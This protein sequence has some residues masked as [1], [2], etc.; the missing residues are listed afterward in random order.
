MTLPPPSGQPVDLAA[1]GEAAI[2]C[3]GLV[4][5]YGQTVAVAGL[6]LDFPKGSFFGL[7]GPNGAGKTTTLSMVTGLLRP[8]A[9]SVRV[10]GKDVWTD[11][12]AAKRMLGVLP[13]GMRLFDRLT[14]L[15]LVTYAGLLRGMDRAVVVGR[16][17]ELLAA[18]GLGGDASTLVVDY[19]AGMTKKV[20]LACA[21][22]HAPRVLVLDEPF[23]GVD[24]VSASTIK[25]ILDSYVA[26][27]RDGRAVQPRHGAGRAPVLARRGYRG[28]PGPRCRLGR[29]SASRD[30]PAG[31]VRRPRRGPHPHRR[32]VVVAHLVRLKLLLL[33]N[34]LKRRPSQLIGLG[35][36]VLYGGF[37]VVVACAGLVALRFAPDPRLGG[38]LVTVLGS[39]LVLAWGVVPLFAFGTDPT[40][41]PRRFATFAISSRQ[42]ALGLAASGLVGLPALAWTRATAAMV[43]NPRGVTAISASEK[44]A[45]LGMF[46]RLP[47]TPVGAVAARSLT[48]WRRDPRYQVS[49]LALLLVPLVLLVA[50]TASGAS[51]TAFLGMPVLTRRFPVSGPGVTVRWRAEGLPGS[52]VAGVGR[53]RGSLLSRGALG[54]CS[55]LLGR[56]TPRR[57]G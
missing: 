16:A 22:V 21:L 50:S 25:E 46:G 5:R 11:P 12:V 55:R 8:D 54:C 10:L 6:D 13:D 19:S 40:L 33:R 23:E 28:G 2:R 37:A 20:A 51:G 45:G 36:G 7:V 30:E 9:G 53:W 38:A 3:R 47:G 29:R 48:M 18:L 15:Q 4:K 52:R 34:G 1:P 31:P 39:V 49:A 24:P 41:D 14:G 42:L 43:E 35:V 57:C 56:R 27:G 32:A 17:H 44:V 26:S